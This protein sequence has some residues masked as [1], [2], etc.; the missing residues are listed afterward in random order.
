MNRIVLM[1]AAAS[2][3]VVGCS[4]HATAQGPG[5][6]DKREK[7]LLDAAKPALNN[8][9]EELTVTFQQS[10][11]T[12]YHLYRVDGCGQRYTSLLHCTGPVC[13]WIEGPE[14]LAQM[15]LQCP[16]TQISSTYAN[17]VFTVSGCG[18]QKNYGLSKGKLEALP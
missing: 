8:C 14:T 12:N 15:D 13:N 7:A 3:L 2:L 9:G 10:V 16:G 1:V 6:N 11:E 4:K 5:M 18:R 17:Q